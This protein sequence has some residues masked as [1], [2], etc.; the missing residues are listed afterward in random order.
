MNP[1]F[2]PVLHT[3][4][5]PWGGTLVAAAAWTSDGSMVANLQLPGS[6]TASK[7]GVLY[8][9]TGSALEVGGVPLNRRVRQQQ[10]KAAQSTSHE[11]RSSVPTVDLANWLATRFCREDVVDIKMDIE[12]AEFEVLEH[13]LRSSHAGLIDT[14]AVEWHTTKRGQGGALM[15]LRKR[16]DAILQGLRRAG[17]RLVEW[18]DARAGDLRR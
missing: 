18:K 12:G 5:R 6:R 15:S 10:R 2:A 7:G 4:L 1:V 8:N 3:L 14:L 13:M 11:A 9:M 17:V 16:Q